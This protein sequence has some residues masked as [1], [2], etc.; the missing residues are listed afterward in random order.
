MK[1]EDYIVILK[2]NLKKYAAGLALG[3]LWVFQQ[4]NDPKH[5]S[6]LVQN[7]IRN[8]PIQLKVKVHAWKPFNLDE[9]EQFAM[10]KWSEIP[11]ETCTKVVRNH[12]RESEG[13]HYWL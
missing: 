9:L 12:S 6:Q 5:T 1:K 4:D 3:H 11:Q 13:L 2:D 8:D 7:F 10:E